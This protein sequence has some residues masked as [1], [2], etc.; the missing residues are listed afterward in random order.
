MKPKNS[1][2]IIILFSVFVFLLISISS[3]ATWTLLID[4]KAETNNKHEKTNVVF[5]KDQPKTNNII[6]SKQENENF[7]IQLIVHDSIVIFPNEK[8]ISNKKEEKTIEREEIIEEIFE[9]EEI[10]EEP[11]YL[12]YYDEYDEYD[13]DWYEE[14]YYDW[15]YNDYDYDYY[16]EQQDDY[17]YYSDYSDLRSNIVSLAESYVGVTPYV[18]AGD[19]LIEGTDCSGFV[20][21][22]YD[23]YGIYASAGS[24]DYQYEYQHIGYEDLQPGD[25]VV[26]RDGGHIGIYAGD[27]T[28]IHCANEDLGTIE[29]DMWYSEPTAF[30]NLID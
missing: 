17:E 9:D 18:W 8:Q 6:K 23:S 2:R 29:S 1:K 15:D 4:S 27:D 30:V 22:I 21:L 5:L 10:Y 24:D 11:I 20:S 16:E 7:E 12:A 3:I 13:Y 26:Y 28:V 25:I 14:E 19:S